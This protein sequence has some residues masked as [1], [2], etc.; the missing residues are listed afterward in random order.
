[1]SIE[2]IQKLSMNPHFY[3]ILL[4]GFLSGYNK[5]CDVRSVFM[6]LPILLY[7]ESRKKLLSANNRSKM[8]T[9]FNSPEVLSENL[10]VSGK[11]R[12]SGYIQRFEEL[13]ISCKKALVILYSDKKI[14][15]NNYKIVLLESISYLNYSGTIKEWIRAS[16]YLGIVFAKTSEDHLNYFLG[17]DR[18]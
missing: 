15:L 8:E 11:V 18:Q 4:Q 14:A 7:S 13:K 9:L 1:M 17:V 2:H 16:Y 10:N 3:G 6:A 12:L 5:P